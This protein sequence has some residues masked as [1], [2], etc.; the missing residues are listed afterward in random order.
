MQRCLLQITVLVLILLAPIV[1]YGQS[2]TDQ[3]QLEYQRALQEIEGVIID[4][5]KLDDPLVLVS[6]K[7][8]TASLVWRYDRKRAQSLF[9][10][11]WKYID[12]QGSEYL[13]QDEARTVLLR[14]LFPVDSSLA[15]KLLKELSARQKEESTLRAQATGSDP[16]PRRLANISAGLVD[17]DT[18]TAARLLE[19]SLSMG[20]T[21][22]AM[23]VLSRM[24]ERNPILANYVVSQTLDHI[25]SRPTIVA[26]TGLHLLTAYIFPS[27]PYLADRQEAGGTDDSLR[28]RYF[29]TA[30]DVLKAS[31][32]ETDTVL[33]KEKRYTVNDL[34]F[35]SIY[36]G[37][38]AM[39]LAALAPR[40][41]PQFFEELVLLARRLSGSTPANIANMSSYIVARLKG[42]QSSSD[43][44]D[45]AISVAIANG[46]F[47]DARRLIDKLEDEEKRKAFSQALAKAE[48]KA[49]VGEANFTE[50]L[51][52]ARRIENVNYA[53]HALSTVGQSRV[54]KRRQHFFQF[55]VERGPRRACKHGKERDA[56]K[57]A[58][59]NSV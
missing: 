9:M 6:V 44:P 17:Q 45:I 5:G 19:Q 46:D 51:S 12:Q 33:T 39:I 38:I 42:E 47:D 29:S 18:A 27:E 7:S 36:Q 22:T 28:I 40:Y 56:C 55:S 59:F 37:Q 15:G 11:L 50:A 57:V 25:R 41:G 1:L 48:F 13:D 14:N 3:A 49:L 54:Q 21:P 30:Y 43:N 4:T 32:E 58:S 10:D 24:R 34:R 53:C 2:A 35:R 23:A 26:L 20:V 16:G 8:R 52:L 31:L